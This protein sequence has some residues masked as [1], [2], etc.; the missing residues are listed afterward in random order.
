M[1]ARKISESAAG[2]N[3]K[4]AKRYIELLT[5]ISRY[6]SKRSPRGL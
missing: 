5:R 1:S 2:G 3:N 4:V 6:N